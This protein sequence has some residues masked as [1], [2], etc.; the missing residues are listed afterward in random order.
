MTTDVHTIHIDMDTLEYTREGLRSKGPFEVSVGKHNKVVLVRPTRY[1]PVRS[2][3]TGFP[4]NS[5]FPLPGTLAVG[6]SVLPLPAPF[7]HS[8]TRSTSAREHTFQ[9]FGHASATG[10]DAH[11]KMLA[12]RRAKVGAAL[13]R[14]SLAPVLEVASEE[15]WGLQHTQ[16]MLRTLG[17]DPGPCDGEEGRLTSAALVD[18]VDRYNQEIFH[19]MSPNA[20]VVQG[21]QPEGHWSEDVA[22]AVIDA[23]VAA[24]G[25]AIPEANLVRSS[26]CSEFNVLDPERAAP[27]RRLSVIASATAPPHPESA[28]C[29]EGDTGPCALVDDNQQRCMWYREHVADPDPPDAEIF[30][31]RWLWL[32]EDKYLLSA[33]TTAD[34]DV[35]FTFEVFHEAAS[36]RSSLHVVERVRPILGTLNAVW[37]SGIG[38]SDVDGQPATENLPVFE[39]SA[40]KSPAR[41]SAKWP[42]RVTARILFGASESATFNDSAVFK[43]TASDG[44]Y[45]SS[46]PL[47]AARRVS[48]QKVAL[49]FAS[50]P[51]SALVNLSF[52]VSGEAT[53]ELFRDVQ[54]VDMLDNCSLGNECKEIPPLAPPTLPPEGLPDHLDGI[55]EDADTDETLVQ[56]PW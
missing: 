27:N 37:V 31:A 6:W 12:D 54:L 13:L 26:G 50:V 44:S 48:P 18:F 51:D 55:T 41:G 24:H 49:E 11:N 46:I 23:F 30:A 32:G 56:R 33:L 17:L 14:S 9:V 35:D 40:A 21:L 4:T 22:R 7:A 39:V 34:E 38:R 2:S 15:E 36:E 53:Y 29:T 43:L 52:G 8:P 28:P 1:R 16:A 42:Q 25:A 3:A 5:A 45:A 19:R 10:E 20:P 47:S